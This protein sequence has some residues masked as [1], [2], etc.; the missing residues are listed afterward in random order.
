MSTQSSG[1]RLL[2]I[3]FFALFAAFWAVPLFE[4]V[5]MSVHGNVKFGDAPFVGLGNYKYMLF[6]Q[7]RYWTAVRNTAVFTVCT[8]GI[9]LPLA[10]LFF[11]VGIEIGQIAFIA[12]VLA[13][14]YILR[15]PLAKWEDRLMPV[16][17]YI[18][19]ALSAMWCIERGL[20]ALS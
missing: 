16:P 4:G 10:L 15:L 20:E 17:V 3:P 18:L 8:V 9:I 11:N 12:V 1:A 13:L 7:P 2:L 14:W 5:W 19:G 6:D